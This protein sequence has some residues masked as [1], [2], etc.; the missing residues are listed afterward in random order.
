MPNRRTTRRY[1]PWAIPILLLALGHCRS[2][3]GSTDALPEG[4]E[5]MVDARFRGDAD[6]QSRA[7]MA[8]GHGYWAA[9][10][11]VS[12]VGMAT[13]A[14]CHPA[15]H[16]SYIQTG[17]GRS[18]APAS[19]ERSD[20]DF[21]GHPE[22]FD[23]ERDLHY[24][25]FWRGEAL[26]VAEFRL[27]GSDTVH[28]REE[29]VDH[30]I[31]SGQH[32]NSHLVERDGYLYQAPVTF[33]T[34]EG[35]WDLAPGFEGGYST[36][37][38]RPIETE[39]ITCHNG[40]SVHRAGTRNAY[41]AIPAGIDCERCH[42]PGAQHVRQ[43][44]AGV[45]VDTAEH[46]DYSIVNP[47]KLALDRQLDLCQRCHLQGVA[48][49]NDGSDWYDFRPGDR[50]QEH[51]NVFLP[52]FG[53]L[54]AAKAMATGTAG[55]EQTTA[56]QAF[57]MASQAERLQDSPCF[58]A[59]GGFGCITCHNP[60]V[61]VRVTARKTFNAACIGCHGG[62]KHPQ[63]LCGLPLAER[64]IP[65]DAWASRI[66]AGGR[67][68]ES[69]ERSNDC[70]ACH[71]PR[72]GAVD[73][74]HVTITDHKV[75]VPKAQEHPDAP[76]SAAGPA[77][78]LGLECLT[79]SSPDPLTRARAY[80]RFHE[81]FNRTAAMLDSA[82]AWLARCHPDRNPRIDADLLVRSRLHALWLRG[83]F[84]T[85]AA[86]V[87]DRK[88]D[89][90]EDAWACYRAGEAFAALKQNQKAEAW[91]G[92]SAVLLPL[93]A[94]MQIKHANA[95]A[96]LGRRKEAMAGYARALELNPN[97]ADAHSNLGYLLL[98]EG[99]G[100]AAET[101][102]R[103]ACALDPDYLPARLHLI[104]WLALDGQTKAARDLLHQSLEMHPEAPELQALQARLP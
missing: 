74:P 63:G 56:D 104:Q 34:Q 84:P 54:P 94:G 11:S 76:P 90:W 102:F 87:A 6:P 86:L 7:S 43:K 24:R 2:Q 91:F 72:S 3:E 48:V 51:W 19:R 31:G 35:R 30:I 4:V 73:I 16:Q 101:H 77:Q 37:F 18:F 32:T 75:R 22:V 49:L 33:Y 99:A 29:Q 83:D 9:V 62:S 80:L 79:D 100:P 10:D 28:Y 67:L 14:I 88:P 81:A 27:L 12:Y 17:M 85:A 1:W 39:C 21:S 68:P 25:P 61:S 98:Q 66:Y 96:A 93:D 58:L 78:F 13:C 103:T 20:A 45:L 53:R 23:A 42:G 46:I 8:P 36:R 65:E 64:V 15:Q 5:A 26:M 70:S 60:H 57:L 38:E 55:G 40:H 69:A 82:E 50:I 52:D 71:M 89:A 97:R 92:R 44:L 47:G 41:E 59:T 95:L